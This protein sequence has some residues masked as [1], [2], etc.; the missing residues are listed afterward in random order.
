MDQTTWYVSHKGHRYA[1]GAVAY[2]TKE[3]AIAEA[4]RSC[5]EAMT[6]TVHEVPAGTS[7]PLMPPPSWRPASRLHNRCEGSGVEG[8]VMSA[9]LLFEQDAREETD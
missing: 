7:A 3:A 9:L 5:R 2:K 1:I 4:R 6:T 8:F